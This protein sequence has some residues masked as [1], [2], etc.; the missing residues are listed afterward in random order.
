MSN[1]EPGRP[2]PPDP[3]ADAPL[4]V[5]CVDEDPDTADSTAQ[6]LR[7]AGLDARACYSG[8]AALREAAG[9]APDVCLLDLKLRG[10][11]GDELGVQ[12]RAQAGGRPLALV[13]VTALG[14]TVSRDRTDR[15]GF[16]LHLVKPVHP[17][18]LLHVV[19]DLRE[20]HDQA[21]TRSAGG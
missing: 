14:D 10:V 5:L 16:D 20:A 7:M 3:T 13:A 9:F 2:Q 6:L 17:R 4:R 15:A 8:P 1:T 21:R 19:E 12:L 18:D 11:G